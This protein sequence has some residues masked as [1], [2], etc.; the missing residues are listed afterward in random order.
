V[1][2]DSSI[3]SQFSQPVQSVAQIQNGL[4]QGQLAR[5][6]LQSNALAMQE[7]QLKLQGAQQDFADTNN[8]RAA[9]RGGAD[10]STPE[11]MRA[12]QQAAPL[13]A[14]K[15][16]QAQAD[17]LKSR[18]E[19]SKFSAQG[20][21][22]NQKVIVSK[23]D[24]ASRQLGSVNTPDDATAFINH[25]FDD[26]ALG[27]MLGG[28]PARQ[29]ELAKIAG[30]GNDPTQL[31]AWKNNAYSSALD[32]K[33]LV[34]NQTT[35]RGQDMTQQTA[36]TTTGMNNKTTLQAAAGNNAATIGAAG[37]GAS[38]RIQAAKIGQST[39]YGLAGMNPDGTPS[40]AMG[41]VSAAQAAGNLPAPS[42]QSMSRPGGIAAAGRILA[43]NPKYDFTTVAAKADAAKSFTDGPLGNS[44]RSVSTANGHLDQ[45]LPLV[46]ALGNGNMQLVNKI[47]N[48]V[49][50]QFGGTALTNLDAVKN[51][52]GQEVVK[53]IVAGGG[54]GG[55]R[56]AATD[57]FA[58]ASSP[59]QLKEVIQHY[60]AI[61]GVQANNL[62]AQRR[63]AGLPDSTIPNYNQSAAQH[64]ADIQ[65]LLN[66]YAPKK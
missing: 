54:T 28:E 64:P 39:Q 34:T 50:K 1:P 40:A 56:D 17:L 12:L 20:N 47:G 18:A 61:M 4:M 26:P 37:I 35:Q 53:A 6:Q 13:Q 25:K 52:I 43:A 36:F 65:Q 59:Q 24:L 48:S 42:V 29:A 11:G 60:R 62:L 49:S 8:L 46:D 27:P 30:M 44:L 57:A 2:I 31:A 45:M 21:E 63:A 9:L 5:S 19:T 58:G 32:A 38:S 22:A 7:G 51:V 33:D 14:G 23:L 16:L 10:P 41:A 66:Q 3:Y 15:F 55:E